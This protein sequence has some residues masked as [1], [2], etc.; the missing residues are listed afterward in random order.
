M[1][2]SPFCRLHS[3]LIKMFLLSLPSAV[4]YEY[5]MTNKNDKQTRTKCAIDVRRGRHHGGRVHPAAGGD[6]MQQGVDHQKHSIRVWRIRAV[7]ATKSEWYINTTFFSHVC[8]DCLLTSSFVSPPIP[9]FLRFLLDYAFLLSTAA[10]S[11]FIYVR[12]LPSI[13]LFPSDLDFV[14][15]AFH[16]CTNSLM[17]AFFC[18]RNIS[19]LFQAFIHFTI[20]HFLF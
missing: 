16:W 6:A 11:E 14:L 8:L 19:V 3:I 10:F 13:I 4:A 5:M 18:L 9:A 15:F 1:A 7:L 20:R 2:A 12:T 17:S